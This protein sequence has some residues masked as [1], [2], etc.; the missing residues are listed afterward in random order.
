MER[1]AEQRARTENVE[2][3]RRHARRID[4]LGVPAPRERHAELADASHR[5]EGGHLA[6]KVHESSRR[7]RLSL[8]RASARPHEDE[9][10]RVRYGSGRSRTP[11]MTLNIALL[12]PMPS[13]SVRTATAVKAFAFNS[14]LVA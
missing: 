11:L 2:E 3:V 6:A 9:T 8:P 7:E 5:R 10:A 13:V 4:E 12:A 14:D 1:V